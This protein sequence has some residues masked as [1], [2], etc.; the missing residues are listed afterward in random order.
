MVAEA[1]LDALDAHVEPADRR[2][3]EQLRCAASPIVQLTAR[4]MLEK[5]FAEAD[6]RDVYL[7]LLEAGDDRSR[8]LAAVGLSATGEAGDHRRLLAARL[9]A[10]SKARRRLL[11]AAAKLDFE[12]SRVAMFEDLGDSGRG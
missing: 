10:G 6:H 3:L 4:Y 11:G 5:H 7:A 9:N 1:A 12:G 2:L 8:M